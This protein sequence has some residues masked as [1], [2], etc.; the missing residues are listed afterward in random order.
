M[1]CLHAARGVRACMG[2]LTRLCCA[3]D[4]CRSEL[5][6]ESWWHVLKC[7]TRREGKAV[8]CTCKMISHMVQL[9]AFVWAPAQLH[10]GLVQAQEAVRSDTSG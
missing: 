2:L 6:S 5:P 7:L 4:L 3:L 1:C 10:L 9:P 8:S